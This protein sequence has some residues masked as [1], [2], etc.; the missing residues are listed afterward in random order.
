[1]KHLFHLRVCQSY[2]PPRH[3]QASFEPCAAFEICIWGR[4][5]IPRRALYVYLNSRLGKEITE[6]I[7]DQFWHGMMRR[8]GM[9]SA[10]W[11]NGAVSREKKRH[12]QLQ[13]AKEFFLFVHRLFIFSGILPRTRGEGRCEFS[14]SLFLILSAVILMRVEH[15]CRL[16]SG[17][18]TIILFFY[19]L[20]T[21][22]VFLG[23]N[24][25]STFKGRNQSVLN[26]YSLWR[27]KM[28]NG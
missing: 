10:A 7:L 20:L 3:V 14:H 6:A 18:K 2:V 25:V 13:A 1:M 22:N 17:A 27:W 24:Q 15:K 5:K 23:V 26:F 9:K 8:G 21:R 19:H 4:N 11:L 16:L 28:T 12:R